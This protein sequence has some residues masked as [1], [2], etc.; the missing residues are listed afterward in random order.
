MNP[1][2]FGPLLDLTNN[3]INKVF[4]NPADQVEA[5]RKLLELQQSGELQA[6]QIQMSAILA[7]AQSSDPWT[8]RARPAF[9]YLFYVIM[10]TTVV[11]APII[12][13]FFPTQMDQFFL[14]VSKGFIA[15]PGEVW[16]AFTTGYLGYGALRT[17]E[18]AKGIA[19]K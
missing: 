9:L 6:A 4:P 16:A 11:I 1:L 10:L 18:K 5:Q 7:E 14:N 8:S 2:L 15:I 13:I 19:G 17:V 3:I 12:G